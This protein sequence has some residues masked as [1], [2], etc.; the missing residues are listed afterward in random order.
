MAT[1]VRLTDVQFGYVA[2]VNVDNIEMVRHHDAPS[3]KVGTAISTDDHM[4][5]VRES[6]AEV[7]ALL[8]SLPG[9]DVFPLDE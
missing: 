4:Y 5:V 1:F 8:A 2:L 3:E 9:V 7:E 6:I